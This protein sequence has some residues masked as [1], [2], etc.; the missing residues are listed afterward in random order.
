ML[1]LQLAELEQDGIIQKNIYQEI[2]LKT[3]YTLT[4]FGKTLE[5]VVLAMSQWGT[6]Y[7][8]LAKTESN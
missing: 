7:N 5:P 4:K 3:D 1:A 2:P 8:Q 6:Y